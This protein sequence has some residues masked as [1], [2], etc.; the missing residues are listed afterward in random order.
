[1]DPTLVSL[2]DST[3]EKIV[4]RG[5]APAQAEGPKLPS[6]TYS[7]S[8]QTDQSASRVQPDCEGRSRQL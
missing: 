5:P 1:M 3:P 6:C 2:L 4:P 7:Q 8:V